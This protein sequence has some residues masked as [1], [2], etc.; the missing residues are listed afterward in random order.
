MVVSAARMVLSAARVVVRAAGR[1]VSAFRVVL[2]R[3]YCFNSPLGRQL[4]NV[5]RKPHTNVVSKHDII[6]QQTVKARQVTVVCMSAVASI[7][8]AGASEARAAI[9]RQ[10]L[11]WLSA[12]PTSPAVRVRSCTI[13]SVIMYGTAYG[14]RPHGT[15]RGKRYPIRLNLQR[16]TQHTAQHTAQR[17]AQHTAYSIQ[18]SAQHSIQHSAQH[19]IQHSAQHSIQHVRQLAS[20]A[21]SMYINTAHTTQHGAHGA[22]HSA[23]HVQHLARFHILPQLGECRIVPF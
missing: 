13:G 12:Q 19:S 14:T 22:Q 15:P 20:T 6:L 4:S 21:R 3:K 11:T 2:G 17:T 1:V 5:S 9:S 16:T 23:Q 10:T 8:S 18:H 7:T